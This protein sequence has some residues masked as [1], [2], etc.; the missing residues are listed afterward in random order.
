M[1]RLHSSGPS[2]ARDRNQDLRPAP[3][4]PI[5]IPILILIVI[6][7]LASAARPLAA[8]DPPSHPPLAD[9]GREASDYLIAA[10]DVLQVFVWKEPELSTEATVR[11]DG[12]ISAPLL[13]DIAAAGRT[14]PE[15]ATD[16]TARLKSFV[17]APQVTISL[18]DARSARVFVVGQVNRAG[19]FPL[20]TRLTF[21]QA[22][23]LA[24]GFGPYAKQDRVLIV[25]QTG[26]G[27]RTLT[28]D[29]KKLE[30]GSDMSLNVVLRPGDTIV[31]P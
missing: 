31:V 14:L 26:E 13:G 19:E 15:L 16:V 18:K 25:R 6:G 17:E 12:K 9:A 20:G 24:G 11:L 4:L 27:P 7:L 29:Y 3:S 30:A 8:A 10:G 28:V 5:P 21:L 22:L 2:E 23:A 1:S